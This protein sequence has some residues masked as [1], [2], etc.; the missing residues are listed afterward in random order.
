MIANLLAPTKVL[1]LGVNMA[2][3]Y[4]TGSVSLF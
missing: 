2:E 4:S 3:V 1:M